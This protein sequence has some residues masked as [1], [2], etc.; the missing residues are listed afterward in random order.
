VAPTPS[1]PS[2][3]GEAAAAAEAFSPG[4]GGALGRAGGTFNMLGDQAP[5]FGRPTPPPPPHH[6]GRPTGVTGLLATKGGTAVP[7]IRSFKIADN[8][9]PLPQDRVFFNFNYWNN[10]NYAIARKFNAPV[11]GIQVYRYLGGVEKTFLDGLASVGITESINNLTAVSST[12]GLGGTHTAMGDVSFFTKLVLY[13]VWDDNRGI[14]ALGGFGYPAQLGGAGRNG[15]LISGGLAVTTPTGPGG[16]AGASFSKS[17]RD[18]GLQPYLAYFY[19]RGNFY[20]QGFESIDVPTDP[21]DVTIIFNDIGM[22][23]YLYRNPNLDTF[24]TAFA[25][26]FEVHANVPVNHTDIGNP[27][28][29]VAIRAVVDLTLGANFQFGQRTVLLLGAVTPVTGPRPYSVEAL[30]LL[31]FYFGGRRTRPAS[32]FPMAGQ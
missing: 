10:V 15:F 16:L 3:A 6:P 23:Y 12:A 7:W 18:V 26:T 21:R 1:T 30:A 13:Q 20:L 22:G 19:S 32:A 9:S 31:N 29:P 14:N 11:S 17:F 28:D 5:V 2:A 25:P 4:E 27:S 8:Q 24:F